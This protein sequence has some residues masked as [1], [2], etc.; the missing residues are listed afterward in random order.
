MFIQPYLF[1]NGR[2]EEALN[3][4]RKVLGAEVTTMLRFKDS[5]DPQAK[6][7]C[8]PGMDEKVMHANVQIRDTQIMAS[9]GRGE[10]PRPAP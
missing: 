1:F 8:G 9:D 2:C 6:A 10:G 7:G 4:Y 5:P 3:F